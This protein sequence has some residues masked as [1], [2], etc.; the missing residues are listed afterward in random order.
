MNGALSAASTGLQAQ[1]ANIER[2]SSDLANVNT[3]GY[4]RSRNEF[5][6][7]MY[8]TSKAPGGSLGTTTMTPVGIQRGMGV[9]V[10][11]THKVFEQGPA[12]MTYNPLDLLIQG[13][14]FFALQLANGEIGYTRA[15]AFHRDPQ[16]RMLTAEGAQLIPQITIPQNSIDL[17]IKPDGEVVAVMQDNSETVIGQIQ[18]VSFQND[19]GLSAEGSGVYK[20]TPASGP[21]LQGVPGEN[22]LGA[23][24]QG[25][26]EG[27]N[28][29]VPN[30]MVDM[31]TTQRA[32]EMGTKVMGAVDQM[33]SATN[34][35][36]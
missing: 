30:S 24:Q 25:A 26:L 10:G 9:K 5:Q 21:P 19:E 20:P 22:T 1:Q 16:G 23:L 12:R 27:S 36:K 7:L 13:K 14:G 17:K 28:V 35:M 31:I 33:M 34:Q 2:I 32:Y 18:L 4:K 15:G 6:D 11:A 8:E 29:N 3:D